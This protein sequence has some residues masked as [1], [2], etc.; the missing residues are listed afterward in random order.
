V[1]HFKSEQKE[2]ELA[3]IE[4]VYKELL[5]KDYINYKRV[6]IKN[7]KKS[8]DE[9]LLEELLLFLLRKSSSKEKMQIVSL[10]DNLKYNINFNLVLDRIYYIMNSRGENNE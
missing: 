9:F 7:I 8:E 4:D 5:K 1:H 10:L 2:N 6:A 3:V